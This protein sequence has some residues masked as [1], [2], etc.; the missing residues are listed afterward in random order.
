M[1]NKSDRDGA[2]PLV[3]ELRNM[4][5]LGER[6][7]DDWQPP[8]VSTV[9]NEGR[10]IDKLVEEI[11]RFRTVQRASGATEQRRLDRARREVES[12][13]LTRLR[14]QLEPG[15]ADRAGRAGRRRSAPASWTRTPR[16]TP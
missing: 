12:I 7:P 4:I 6:G 8:I 10:G 13:A 11:G 14:A 9:A 1:V 3:R 16:P 2:Q 15:S 5:A